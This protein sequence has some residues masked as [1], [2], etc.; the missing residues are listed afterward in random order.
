MGLV[1]Q[2]ILIWLQAFWKAFL[3]AFPTIVFIVP[4][5]RMVVTALIK[6]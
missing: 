1:D 5:V 6:N 4:K 2:F 3:I